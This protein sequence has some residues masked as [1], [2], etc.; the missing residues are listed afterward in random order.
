M[1]SDMSEPI[2]PDRAFTAVAPAPPVS[3]DT[4]TFLAASRAPATVR[5]YRSDVRD[6]EA[7]CLDHGRDPMP[8]SAELVADY[9]S[10]LAATGRSA[11]TITRRLSSISQAHQM[12]RLESPTQTQLVRMTAAGIR[13]TIS[14]APRQARP[15]VVEELR[16]MLDALPDGLRGARDRALLLVGF[17]GAFRRSE[18]VALVVEDVQRRPEGLLIELRRSKTDQEG[19][20]RTVA[21][22]HGRS[23]QTDPAAALDEWLGEAGITSGPLFREVD[24]A[25]RVGAAALSDKA[26]TRIVK[27]AAER[28]GIDPQQVSGHSLRAGLAT[29]AAAAGAPERAIMNTTG[30]RSTAMVRRYI[31]Q[32][33]AFVE[34][35]SRY[36]LVL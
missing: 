24:R 21:I 36:L 9:I 29:S 4:R 28:I 15:I 23:P 27:G 13:R 20:G 31:R 8:A 12:A 10:D 25:G 5:A 19:A 18:L 11:A 26:V 17:A 1:V 30:H 2:D 16:L 7:W 14:T 32:G 35:A 33:S 3:D 22:V 6:F 34:S